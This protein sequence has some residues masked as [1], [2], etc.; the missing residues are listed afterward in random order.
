MATIVFREG[1]DAHEPLPEKRQLLNNLIDGMAHI[2][3]NALYAEF[4]RSTTSYDLGFYKIT[5][6]ALANAI[7]GVAWWLHREL[8]PGTK[9]E[10]L[11]YI[12]PSDF[13]HNI[14]LLGAVKAG[15]KVR[16]P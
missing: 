16:E 12:G 11:T 10:T 4:P 1:S 5:Y 7:N 3:P 9:F 6:A 13:R 14:M 8:G 15:Y 2:R